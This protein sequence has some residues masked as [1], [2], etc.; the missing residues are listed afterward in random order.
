[1][2]K[3]RSFSN[4]STWIWLLL[5][6]LS[7]NDLSAASLP[8]PG[9]FQQE[10]VRPVPDTTITSDSI[11]VPRKTRSSFDA[12]VDRFAS[13]SIVQD[14]VNGKVYL[15]GDAVVNYEDITLKAAIIEVDFN[16]NTVYAI[17]REDSTGKMIGNPEFT[18]GKQTFKAK[19]MTYNFDTGKGMIH[20]VLTEDGQGFLHGNKVKKMDD[21]TI[22]ILHGAYTTCNLEENPHF[23]FKFKKARVMP[24]NK[25]VTGP[26]Y[27]EIEGVPT[28]LALPFG[29]F[30]NKS[31]Q[32]S[33]IVIP[34]YGESKTRGFF[35]ENGGYYWAIN[36]N[37]D[38]TVLGDV[39]SRGSW[40]IKPSFRYKKRYKYSG[41]LNLGYAVNIEG[42]KGAPDYNKSTDFRIRWVFNQDPKAR[43]RGRFS[44]DVNIVTSNYVKYNVVSTEDYLS[45]TFQSSIAYQTNWGGGKYNLTVNSTFSQN[46]KTHQVDV[47]LPQLT[48]SVSR[49]NPLRKAGGK[50]RFYEDLAISYSMNA[51]NQINTLDSLLFEPTVFRDDMQNGAIHKIPISLP[52]KILK[53]FTLSN[54][55]NITDRMYSQTSRLSWSTDTLFVDNDTTVG[56]TKVDTVLGFRNAIDFGF[57]SSLS[58]RV[59]GML[60]FKKGPLR[61]IRHVLT[62]SL[63]ISYVPDFGS[64]SWGYYDSYIDGDGNEIEYSVFQ[65]N[66]FK[67]IANT[68]PGQESGSI[69]L[70]FANNLEIKVR[71]RKDTVTGTKKIKLIEAFTIGGSYDLAKDSLNMS[72]IRM[73]GR[74]TLY[75]NITLQYSSQWDPYAV[76]ADGKRTNKFE[77][78]VNRRLLRH[79]NTSWNLSIGFKLGDKD[80]KKKKKPK[81]AT[82]EQVEQIKENRD[83]YVDWDVPW[84]LDLRYNFQYRV[85]S[86]Y[87]YYQKENEHKVVQTLSLRGQINITPKWKFTFQTGWDFTKN[88]VSYTSINIYRDLHCWEMRFNWVPLGARA[89]W[90]FS[91]NVKASILQDLKLNRKKD[92]RDI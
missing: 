45:N 75:K 28:P 19:T 9:F 67:S 91:I 2:P 69:N 30:P 81:D 18:E 4:L 31:G 23:A 64:E 15:Y 62:P 92:F 14:L 50:K 71:S 63:G 51:R 86:T 49:F 56:Y 87:L 42:T 3:G 25:I 39:F 44:A 17:G 16:T 70:S 74:T 38:L 55:I 80:L 82:D 43:P 36:D 79:N 57:S 40:A 60:R 11:I 13:D 10:L 47:T 33:G 68:P 90:N 65:N 83:D 52:I 84:S 61:A 41:N 35:L 76:D 72:Y 7:F 73:S 77:Y 27:M 22:N 89:S 66:Y 85:N 59:Y 32:K 26:A 34:S 21:N 12:I 6:T 24:D 29:M 1:M 5:L 46:T 78:Q 8:L 48:F 58:T 37:M 53:H 54:S 20:Q 88:K